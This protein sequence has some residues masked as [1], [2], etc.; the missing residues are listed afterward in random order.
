[1]VVDFERASGPWHFEWLAI[2][3][4][5]A[6]AVGFPHQTSFA[7]SGLVVNIDSMYRV[8]CST[9]SLIVGEAFMMG[10]A[11]FI[12][13]QPA[14][15]FVY[16]ACKTAIEDSKPLLDVLASNEQVTAKVS[17]EQLECFCDP[18]NYLGASQAMV[19]DMLRTSALIRRGT[20]KSEG[21]N[22]TP[23]PPIC[24]GVIETVFLSSQCFPY[25]DILAPKK[26]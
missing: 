7:L 11:P 21:I 19:D 26:A 17:K 25:Y 18:L 8:L 16:E 3:E 24:L 10:L 13:R 14:H 5:F 2:P 22:D 9:K 4:T 20:K 6:L 1:M 15:D 23:R 12:R